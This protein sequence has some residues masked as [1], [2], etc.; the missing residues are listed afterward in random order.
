LSPHFL[1][2][3]FASLGNNFFTSSLIAHIAGIGSQPF[4]AKMS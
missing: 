1:I 4:G 2:T 3:Y